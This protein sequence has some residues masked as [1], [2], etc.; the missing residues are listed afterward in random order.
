MKKRLLAVC[1]STILLIF[2]TATA[3]AAEAPAADAQERAASI[4][5]IYDGED[6]AEEAQQEAADA[7]E[8]EQKVD[9]ASEN[10]EEQEADADLENAEEQEADADLENAED[11]ETD[12]FGNEENQETPQAVEDAADESSAEEDSVPAEEQENADAEAAKIAE[13]AAQE[14]VITETAESQMPVLYAGSSVSTA[15]SIALGTTYSGS[16]N[17]TNTQD[18]YKF[19]LPTSGKIRV[20][21]TANIE[22]LY[23]KIFDESGNEIWNRSL[24]WN[25]SS[26]QI[27][28]DESLYLT[29]GT[30]YFATQRSSNRDGTYSFKISFTSAGESFKDV[31]GGSDNSLPTANNITLGSQYKGQIA[32]NDEKDFYKFTLS[33]SGT[34]NVASTA[35]I[36]WIYYKIFD[37]NGSEIWSKSLYWNS[38]SEQIVLDESVY[39]TSGTY[40]FAAQKNSNR[41]GNYSFT[42]SFTSAGE[43]F[44]ETQGGSDNSITAARSISL[45]TTYKGQ[46]AINDDKD[47]YKFTLSS[48]DT[49]EISATA[50]M[51]YVN[52]KIFD[53][54]GSQVWSKTP[55]W[56]SSTQINT[57]SESV[58]LSAG[59]YYFETELYSSYYGNYSFKLGSSI[60]EPGAVSGL[61]IGGRAADALRLNWSKASN[62]S[63]Y[64]IEQYKSGSWTRIA[65]IGSGSTLTYRVEGL[66]AST[67]YQFRMKSFALSGS[68][69]LYSGYTYVNGK[70]N[71]SA[72]TGLKIGGTAKDALR[73][74]WTK[75]SGA[76]GY[77]IEQYKNG[78]WVRIARIANNSTETYRVE[79]LRAATTY[80]FRVQAFAF[81]GSTALY[82]GYQ[83]I[84][85]TTDSSISISA[86][87][88]L[89]IGGRA[90]NALR[91]NWTKNSS[92]SGYIIEQYKN[93]SWTRIARIAS[94]STVTYRVE[95]LSASTK[96]QFRIRAFTF[97][98]ST[99]VY[100]AYKTISGT[101]LPTAVTGLKIGGVA[102]DALRLNWTKNSKASGYIIEQY[103]NGAWVRI[104]R[105]GT[106]STVTYRVENLQPSTSYVF[107]VQAFGFDGSTPLYS[108]YQYVTGTTNK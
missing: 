52:Y 97:S 77:I 105:I 10:A 51:K 56:D 21:S 31:Q 2:S 96:Y 1:L 20:T 3:F 49:L 94:N 74:N 62:A 28:L 69:A 5:T 17:A 27:A 95:G 87:T 37:E 4:E 57:L 54:N 19:T 88:G 65:R 38:S 64:I 68:T 82:S 25:S 104:A 71:P 66:S 53:A 80:K 58:E 47:F 60:V 44:K 73:L 29:S 89:K 14:N 23:Y 42:L 92:A 55:Y 12:S 8:P 22:W 81:D 75:N 98:G 45:N 106:N 9:S 13:D 72:V 85:G 59:T 79:G 33:T 26:E 103:K 11:Q 43:S 108:S 15:T 7:E 93:G 30:Y 16:I 39:L 32:L 86:V 101:T 61:K 78:A 99:P 40:Y 67:T 48:A 34:L 102:R 91:L 90:T 41:Y 84:S 6:S 107:R 50:G 76:S 63:G 24:Y 35:N 83:T 46:L 36:E 70:T 100:S 18:F